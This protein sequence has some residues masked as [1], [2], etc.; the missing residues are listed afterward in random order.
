MNPASR[1]RTRGDVENLE[2]LRQKAERF[3]RFTASVPALLYDYVID[4]DGV[5][6]CLYCSPYSNELFGIPPDAVER[7]MGILFGLIHPDDRDRF[8]AEDRRAN[9]EDTKFF[10]EL[11][12]ILPD[13]QEKWLR[14]SS[15]RNPAAGEGPAIWSGYMIDISE[16]KRAQAL[17]E[18][19]STH[20]FLTGLANRQR[21]QE[22]FEA[23]MQRARRYAT[24]AAVL[25]MDLDRFKAVN[26]RFGHDGGDLVLKEFSGLVQAQLR[27]VDTLARWG[28]EEFTAL[29]P[30]TS[31]GQAHDV[32]E[33]I[34]AAVERHRFVAQ[35]HRVPVTVSIGVCALEQGDDR[36]EPVMRRVDDALYRAKRDGRNRVVAD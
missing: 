1:H 16:T 21:F 14:I 23:E 17:L 10:I 12:V 4:D 32:A 13:G 5:A 35:G 2:A 6:R 26:D 27:V 33:R 25:L 34:R 19:R 28:G 36:I 18:Q 24:P 11:R 20:D 15:S 22:R 31:R 3:D 7:D 29:L 8:H 9:R 30:E